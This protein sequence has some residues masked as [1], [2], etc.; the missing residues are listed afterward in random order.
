ML[1]FLRWNGIVIYK[2]VCDLLQVGD[3]HLGKSR[4]D[5]SVVH[6][7]RLSKFSW[8][9]VETK[10]EDLSPYLQTIQV[11]PEVCNLQYFLAISSFSTWTAPGI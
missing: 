4:A 3:I 1:Y 2:V 8:S 6:Q 11:Q 7:M 9:K 10:S 5:R